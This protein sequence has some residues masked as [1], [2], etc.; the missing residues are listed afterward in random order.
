[1]KVL[2]HILGFPRIGINRELKFAQESYWSGEISQD[3]LLSVGKDLRKKNWKE[4]IKEDIDFITVGDFSWYDHVLDTTMLLGNIPKRHNYKNENIT[5]DT[6]FYIARGR[7][8]EN[9]LIPAS[10]MTKW[11]DTNYHY[12]VPEFTCDSNFNL[13]WLQL[14]EEI[15]EALLM[16]NK[17]KPVILGPLTYLWLGKIKGLYFDKLNLLKKIIPVYQNLLIELKKKNITWVQI[18]EPILVLELPEAWKRSFHFVYESLTGYRKILL[19]TYFGSIN[20]NLDIICKL[21]V[22]GLHLDL[23]SGKCNLSLLNSQIPE[24]WLISLGIINGRNVWRTNLSHWFSKLLELLKFRNKVWIASSCSLLHSPLSI[25][26]EYFLDE[27]V[28]DLFSFAIQKCKELNLLKNALNLGEQSAINLWS[29]PIRSRFNLNLENTFNIQQKLDAKLLN[30]NTR[31]SSYPIRAKKQKIKLNLPVLPITTIGSF[32]QT[33]ELRELRFNFKK[34]N[35]SY[36]EYKNEIYNHIN[37]AISLQED[38]GIDVL[39]HGEFERNDMVEYFGE[40]L[41]GFVFTKNGWVQSYG[42]RCVKPPII[43][44]DVKRSRS[45]TIEWIKYAQSLT[46]KPVKGM[47]T[48]PITILCWSFLREDLSKENIA[49]QIALALRDEVLELENEGINII[50]IDEPA[51][52]EGLPLRHSLWNQYLS[53]AIEMFRLTYSGVKDETQIHT[54]MCYCEFNDIMD[55]IVLLDVDVI[56]IETS[57]SDMELLE[58]FKNFKYPNEIGPGIYDVHSPSAPSVEWMIK[59]LKKAINYIPIKRLWVNPDCG[60]KTRDWEVTKVSLKNMVKAAKIIRKQY[61]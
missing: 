20:H 7:S 52:R 54:H 32:P 53:W 34:G 26:N 55:A 11:F 45:I 15:E 35:L 9:K 24:D 48:G 37:S 6:L 51:L 13:S 31:K 28:K 50:Q 27:K 57:R 14:L 46:K 30:E 23:V 12:I 2:S 59:L 1:M 38:L 22:Q 36:E 8:F 41:S 42:S 40:H 60:L 47:L 39:V 10:D 16:S 61:K 49:K 58:F 3:Q 33:K 25:K 44:G 21:P 4:Q 5:L 56:T 17:V 29:D 18:D 19:T 43:L